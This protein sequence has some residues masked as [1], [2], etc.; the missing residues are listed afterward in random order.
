MA[1][2]TLRVNANAVQDAA[3][4]GNLISATATSTP[5]VTGLI[6]ESVSAAD[7]NY[8]IGSQIDIAVKLNQPVT[9][10]GSGATI[11]LAIGSTPH[12]AAYVSA[13][14][15]ASKTTLL[16]RYTVQEADVATD[17]DYKENPFVWGTLT[18][19]G[20]S[21]LT[22]AYPSP[23]TIPALNGSLAQTSNV[24][25]DGIAPTLI[26]NLSTTKKLD[27]L[28]KLIVN[29]NEPVIGLDSS[30]LAATNTAASRSLS[31][32]ADP[33]KYTVSIAPLAQ[34]Q[35]S[36]VAGV[37]STTVSLQTTSGT[38]TLA[39]G[40][41]IQ[42]SAQTYQTVAAAN[43]TTAPTTITLAS[44][45]SAS[46]GGGDPVYTAPVVMNVSLAAGA[47]KDDAG[48]A[49]AA[50]AP[51]AITY[52]PLS[53]TCTVNGAG[54]E[55]GAAVFTI[56]FNEPVTQNTLATADLTLTN[57]KTPTIIRVNATSFEI[58]SEPLSLS[59]PVELTVKAGA[60][61]DGPGN[62]S[63]IS[64]KASVTPNAQA[65]VFT[66]DQTQAYSTVKPVTFTISSS[67]PVTGL[68]KDDFTITGG[69]FSRLDGSGSS[70][71]LVVDP[72]SN[73][74]LGSP[75]TIS[76]NTLFLKSVSGSVTLE[77]KAQLRLGSQT[78]ILDET[79]PITFGT[80]ATSVAI[81]Q[82]LSAALPIDTEAWQATGLPVAITVRAGAAFDAGNLGNVE[83]KDA[84]K[85]YD[86][87]PPAVIDP[88]VSGNDTSLTYI[89]TFNEKIVDLP[90]T[91][92]TLVGGQIVTVTWLGDSQPLK[93]AIV[94]NRLGS[95]TSRLS[96]KAGSVA[97]LAGNTI[98]ASGPY[99]FPNDTSNPDVTLTGPLS[100][101]P[102]SPLNVQVTVSK[103]VTGLTAGKFVLKNGTATQLNTSGT[104]FVL[105]VTPVP[106]IT[107]T[108]PATSGA[109]VIRCAA[110]TETD[111]GVGGAI[112]IGA[113]VYRLAAG[114]ETKV[115]AEPTLLT[116]S[117]SISENQASGAAVWPATGVEITASLPAGSCEDTEGRTNTASEELKMRYDPTA[118]VFGIS[119]PSG[120]DAQG[121][122]LFNLTPS[123]KVTTLDQTKL[124]VTQGS[125]AILTAPVGEAKVW[126]AAV[127]PV[128]SKSV[129]LAILAG[130]SV[131]N[132]GN[133]SLAASEVTAAI[134]PQV[135]QVTARNANGTYEAGLRLRI[136][137]RFSE[138]V[139]VVGVPTLQLA[140][141]NG[142]LATYSDGSGSTDL[143]F[144]YVVTAGDKSS[145]LDYSSSTALVLPAT[146]TIR[147]VDGNAARLTLPNPGTPGSLG[148]NANLVID[149]GVNT[150]PAKPEVDGAASSGGCGAGSGIA[151]TLSASLLGLSLLR[152]RRAA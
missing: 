36:T 46:A 24:K 129:G 52:D 111:L 13:S 117:S 30:D 118:P 18:F 115:V 11:A 116:L 143:L 106:V 62:L 35:L 22:I 37:G 83:K 89:L 84:T 20:R 78:V 17:L 100:D 55:S 75:A 9:V 104:G 121:R 128:G 126:V 91:A 109:S 7:G 102:T 113:Q 90:E 44:A 85:T 26:L 73:L 137:V 63:L 19:D 15:D 134:V 4:N 122:F 54:M 79:N 58:K 10:A 101:S 99:I 149:A 12:L 25:V 140:L 80:D 33:L 127:T 148:A 70:Y 47:A 123:E 119:A 21:N 34:S 133:P 86:F 107:L 45:L 141:G 42:I 82:S 151:L 120:L 66:I 72:E 61:S 132:A 124:V 77:P 32:T 67:E 43:I 40:S 74:K 68:D 110:T 81:R 3:G 64:N 88:T 103:V 87:V 92:L 98:A 150:N 108:Q 146:A 16:F 142:K 130:A 138:I 6:V 38:I 131:D 57:G 147:D 2:T 114:S 69:K 97:D 145:D 49:S 39:A 93:W 50:L 8:K 53:P 28:T 125:L 144:D 51:V 14:T 139:N 71:T 56:A 152:R 23:S 112:R 27:D 41:P 1:A 94:V 95:T 136:Q 65:P 135:T 96:I 59:S 48:N 31:A 29:T 5:P 76:A 105:P 60:A